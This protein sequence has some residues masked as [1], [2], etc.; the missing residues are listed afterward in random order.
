MPH[1][2]LQVRCPNCH[3]SCELTGADSTCE[4][5]C[6][7]CAT[8]FSLAPEA[9]K[10]YVPRQEMIGQFELLDHLGSGAFGNVWRAKDTILDRQVAL[11]VARSDRFDRSD[12]DVFFREA[13]AAAQLKHPNIVSVHEVGRDGEQLFIVSDLINGADLSDHL[14]NQRFSAREAAG[15]CAKIADGLH[16]AHE[17]GVVHRDLKPQNIILDMAGIPH[18]ADFGQA[19]RETGEMT[20]TLDGSMLGTPS[21]MSPEQAKGESH[22]SDRRTDIYSLGVILFLML[23]GELPFRGT[24]RLLLVQII[25]DPPP[26]LR[27]LESGISRDLETICLK[28]LEKRP[29]H[30]YQTAAELADD[31]GRWLEKKPILASPPGLIGQMVRWSQRKPALAVLT[32]ALIIVTAIGCAAFAWQ[33]QVA[34]RANRELMVTQVHGLRTASPEEARILLENISR[35]A[36]QVLPELRASRS[37]LE[38]TESQRTRFA[39]ALLPFESGEIDY[40]FDRLPDVNVDEVALIREAIEPQAE[41]L[42]LQ[43]WESITANDIRTSAQLRLATAL[44]VFEPGSERW[45]TIAND[46]VAALTALDE[47]EAR[48][49]VQLLSPARKWLLSEFKSLF[50]DGSNQSSRIIAADALTHFLDDDPDRLVELLR[51]SDI[52][53]LHVVIAALQRHAP[54]VLDKIE[55][56]AQLRPNLSN[57]DVNVICNATVTLA[58]MDRLDVLWSLLEADIPPDVRVL[59]IHRLAPCGVAPEFLAQKLMEQTSPAVRRGVLL[60]LGEYESFQTTSRFRESV[61]RHV[62]EIHE[63]DPDSGVHSAAEWLLRKWMISRDTPRQQREIEDGKNW[64]ID[65]FGQTMLVVRGPVTFDLGSSPGDPPYV[66]VEPRQEIQIPYSFAVA[67]TEITRQ[68]FERFSESNHDVTAGPDLACPMNNLT[69]NQLVAYCRWLSLKD[70]LTEDDMCFPPV[71]VNAKEKAIPYEDF[72]SR[73]GY[74]PPTDSEWLYICRAESPTAMFMGNSASM[75]KKYA[76]FRTHAERRTWPVGTLKPNAFGLFDV[77]GNVEEIVVLPLAV[78]PDTNQSQVMAVR[79]GSYLY[80]YR[81]IVWR[82][83]NQVFSHSSLSTQGARIVRTLPAR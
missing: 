73:S 40:L 61:A 67:T 66:K 48:K 9:T 28:C 17:S 83:K 46:V 35:F 42:T 81:Q 2:R 47:A 45:A 63:D 60:A 52:R 25:N 37:S 53:Q 12:A 3:E 34:V 50:E 65:R 4:I 71:N 15:L 43:L 70:G 58:Q 1:G 79:G 72:L 30:R 44:A 59:L 6:D 36:D 57:E 80:D 11:K 38:L 78:P 5:R 27:R 13:R 51:H 14:L 62:A 55:S 76:W 54:S 32:A 31:L 56:L 7:S 75:L 64:F 69:F 24:Y 77:F 10:S 29:E 39:I 33:Y 41:S 49:W 68:Q 22:Q 23:T 19:K 8:R 16:H 26:A 82:S 21:Y 74:R 18:I 20:I